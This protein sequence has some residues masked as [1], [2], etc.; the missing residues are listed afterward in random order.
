MRRIITR[1]FVVFLVTMPLAFLVVASTGDVTAG[2]AVYT[3]RCKMCH[4]EDGSGNPAMAKM[5]TVEFKPLA[6]EYVQNKKD[7]ELKQII[8]KGKGKMAAVRGLSDQQL[9]DVIAY[10]RSLPEE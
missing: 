4:S 3:N 6:S 9:S 8:T 7:D 5:L 2:K 1:A 10:L